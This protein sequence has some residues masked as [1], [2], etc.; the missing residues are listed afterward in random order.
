LLIKAFHGVPRA[1]E[2]VMAHVHESPWI[3]RFPLLF[4]A[5]G[6]TFLG[7]MTD[8]FFM[9]THAH[10]PSWVLQAP[11]VVSLFGVAVAYFF[12]FQKPHLAFNLT[13]HFKYLYIFL[14]NKWFFD[15]IY[16]K[17]FVQGAMLLGNIFWQKGDVHGIDR[18]GPD[19]LAAVVTRMSLILRQVQTGYV[20]HYAFAMMVGLMGVIGYVI[21]KGWAFS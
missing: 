8:H 11:I 2:K 3:M 14:L 10:V 5:I 20:Y 19:G 9:H 4:L 6:A 21:A 13:R 16:H 1:D 12:F 7:F 18:F 17:L 15:K